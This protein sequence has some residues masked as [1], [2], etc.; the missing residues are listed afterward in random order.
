MEKLERDLDAG[1]IEPI[2]V[3]AGTEELLKR[4]AVRMIRDAALGGG[5]PEFNETRLLMKETDGGSIVGACQ[6]FPMM[7]GRRVVIVMGVDKLSES[8]SKALAEYAADPAETTT[9]V[10][11]ATKIDARA[12]LY[13]RA[14]KSGRIL[15]LQAP[16]GRQLPGW[17]TRR[18]R[19]K[20]ARIDGAAATLL[21][22]VADNQLASLDEAIERLLLYVSSADG[23]PHIRSVDVENCIA[24][25]KVNS[26]FE[27]TDALGRRRPGDAVRILDVMLGAR[28]APIRILAMVARHI[29]RLWLAADAMIAGA[30]GDDV[31]RELGVHSYFLDDFIRQSRLFSPREYA[32]LLNRVYETDKAL[33]SS[34]AAPEMHMHRLVLDICVAP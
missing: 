14:A 31:G 22:E 10:L 30:S 25:T 27:L 19:Q 8:D 29:R 15:K 24:R 23:Q 4:E 16:R 17:I 12:K 6:T 28:E 13:K 20:G 32:W 26:V 21:A 11:T 3:V 33:K 5:L 7:G 34:R 18:A 1:K 2:Y 9:L